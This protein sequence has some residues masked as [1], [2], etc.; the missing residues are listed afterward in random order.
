MEWSLSTTL[1]LSLHKGLFGSY[2]KLTSKTDYITFAKNVWK[3]LRK[4]ICSLQ[5]RGYKC[6][7]AS[8]KKVTVKCRKGLLY[9]DIHN[10]SEK[11]GKRH[12]THI[13]LDTA[14]WAK[15]LTIVPVIDE[16]IYRH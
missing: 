11:G 6:Q 9:V 12:H 8:N 13:T 15:L 5:T 14:E 10:I 2:V 7:P 16:V 1:K 4:H 3:M